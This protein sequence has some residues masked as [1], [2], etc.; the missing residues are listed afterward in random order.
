MTQFTKK[1]FIGKGQI[2]I[3]KVGGTTGLIPVGNCSSLE[4]GIE[5]ETKEQQDYTSPGGGLYDS[6]SRITGMTASLTLHDMTAE[7]V[8]MAIRGTVNTVTSAAV[9]EEAHTAYPGAIVA[10]NNVPDSAETIT[11]TDSTGTTTYVK[12]TDYEL[13]NSGILITTG[14]AITA[15]TEIKVSYTS[16]GGKEVEALTVAASTY[17]LYWDGINEADGEP[18]PVELYRVKFSPAAALSLIG[19]EFAEMQIEAA[20]L[21]D[22]TKAGVGV[23]QYAKFRIV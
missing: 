20:V 21:K 17:R 13:G 23:S 7:N 8:A 11:V 15:G 4:L 19:D 16:K 10:L 1:P 6:V 22:D 5:E 9:T 14:G 12:G 3:E 18:M 2:Y